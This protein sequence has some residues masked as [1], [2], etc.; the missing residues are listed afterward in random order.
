MDTRKDNK[1]R[2]LRTGEAQRKNG[3]YMF[4]YVDLTGQRQ[5]VYSWKLTEFDRTPKGKKEDVSLREKEEEINLMLKNANSMQAKKL[6][7][8]EVFEIY[9]EKKRHKGKPLA[10]TTK[11]NYRGE[12]NKNVKNT[13]LGHKKIL[14]IR[15]ADIVSFYSELLEYGLSYGTVLFFHKVLSAVFNYA[16]DAMELIDRNPCRRALD[17][18][19]GSQKETKPLTKAQDKALIQYV[20]EHDKEMYPIFLLMR[21]TMVRLGE[22]VAVTKSDIDFENST[23]TIDKQLLFYKADNEKNGRLHISKTKGRNIRRIPLKENLLQVL[24]ELA[25]KANDN[26]NIDGV[27]GFLFMKDGSVYLPSGLRSDMCNMVLEY[28]VFA[29]DKI[30]E[31]TP[32]TLRH[33][34][35]TMYAR[36]GMDVSVLQY[37]MGHKSSYTTMRFYNHVTEERVQ[38]TFKSHIQKTA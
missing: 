15:K 11:T 9:L 38:D 24:K 25:E 28:N 37:I 8:N 16:M 33:T 36:E 5:T 7:L 6:T 18:I 21:E 22:C 26:F 35:C 3:Q 27:S 31:F 23:I 12:W 2:N 32:K 4:R 34:G 17:N 30:E 20:Y 14:D 1:G 13:V 10:T 29:E 19:E